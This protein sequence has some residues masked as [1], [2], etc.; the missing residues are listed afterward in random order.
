VRRLFFALWPDAALRAAT[1]AA[2]AR[3]VAT[4]GG[5]AVSPDDLHVTLAFLGELPPDRVA[6]ALAVGRAIAGAE[7]GI[8]GTQTF[9]RVVQWGRRGP[10]VLEATR[11]EAGLAEL[12]RALADALLA[13]GFALDRRDFRPHV[14]LSRRPDRPAPAALPDVPG[15]VLAWPYAGFVL[16]ES[17]VEPPP[18]AGASRYALVERFGPG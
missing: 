17:P 16:A 14:T 9:D 10:L 6:A 5:R 7:R 1:V 2:T 11:V 8:G 18:G 12:Q 4:A 13:A 15:G 3:T